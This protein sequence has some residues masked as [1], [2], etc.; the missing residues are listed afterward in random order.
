MDFL[1]RPRVGELLWNTTRLL[2]GGVALS[3]VLGVACAWLV[4]RTDLPAGHLWHGAARRTPRRTRLRERLR[5]GLHDARR[6]VVRRRR[7]DR[8]PLLLPARLPADR[9]RP[10][11]ARLG[12]RGR[13]RGAGPSAPRDVRAGRAAGGQP[14]RPRRGAAGRAAP[15]RRVRRAAD[16]QLPDAHDRD[17]GRSTAS[18]FN[19][20]AATLLALVLMAFCLLLLGLELLAP[21]P[22]QARPRGR[23]RQP[24]R[25]PDAPRPAGPG[26]AWSAWARCRC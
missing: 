14:G 2:V 5:L 17:P 10:A 16:P 22:A 7:A 6:P 21:G 18:T 9:R 25:D 13:R 24:D 1:V 20:P 12:T 4:V 8:Q 26:R 15:P 3:V 23:R 19:G 11:S